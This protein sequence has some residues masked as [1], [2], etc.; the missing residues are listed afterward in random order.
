MTG[1]PS[2]GSSTANATATDN[3]GNVYV[4]GSFSGTVSF[5]TTTLSSLPSSQGSPD[6]FLAKWSTNTNTWAWA[7]RG[8][9]TG[10]DYAYAVAVSGLN[11]YVTG[12]FHSAGSAIIAGTPLTGQGLQDAFVA[13]YFD[14][15][16]T[17]SNGWATSAG[18]SL[19]DG[20]MGVAINGSSVYVAGYAG[21]NATV[22]GTALPGAGHSD[23][24]LAKYID[25]GAT[26]SNGWAVSGGGVLPDVAYGVAV[27][28][29]NVYITGYYD[30]GAT[31]AGTALPMTGGTNVF[32][33]KYVDN[34]SSASNGW[35]TSGGG[36]SDDFGRGIAVSG[37]SM[38]I[39][40]TFGTSNN[41]RLAGVLLTGR[42]GGDMFL[43]KYIDNGSTFT[44]G[45]AT[46]GGGS[47]EDAGNGLAIRNNNIYVSGFFKSGSNV[48]IGGTAMAGYGGFDMFVAKYT[49]NGTTFGNGWTASGGG[50]DT[51]AS[52]G[53][54]VNSAGVF[55]VGTTLQ[56]S[57]YGNLTLA[58]GP[59]ISYNFLGQLADAT[60]LAV[61]GG[62][63]S[64]GPRLQVFPSPAAGAATL[65][66]AA[67]GA[68]VQVLDALGR[69][70][71]RT[72]AD[73]QGTAVLTL[74]AGLYVVRSDG[75]VT[76]LLME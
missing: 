76:R 43:A 57:T 52:Y 13:K 12:L 68:A 39:T 74:A 44:N 28:G 10:E 16:S 9:G 3:S 50:P 18:S 48:S 47:Q 59:G 72:Q 25:N 36:S 46:S 60:G 14:N 65:Q 21:A 45:W 24:F 23:A 2:S 67:P 73:A 71:F 17:V 61:R 62:T 41:A 4:A 6:M 63:G 33:A 27:N 53:V 5:G 75:L 40:G 11:V 31:V 34:G 35:A 66:G 42:G 64:A 70:A 20:A 19:D 58:A 54:A 1:G 26:V 55:T 7:V 32:V 15:G 8:G 51:D 37:N 38:Y 56:T 49:D 69:V 22:A 30:D 29:S